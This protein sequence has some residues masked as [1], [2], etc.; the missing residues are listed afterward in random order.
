MFWD[1]D[2]SP[3][4][5]YKNPTW[6]GLVP[7]HGRGLAF[8]T[9]MAL[10]LLQVLAKSMSVA[11][12]AMT[13]STAFAVYMCADYAMFFAWKIIRGD[14]ILFMPMP[15]VPSYIIS[16]IAFVSI[17]TQMDFT[18]CLQYRLPAF[19]GGSFFMFNLVTSQLSVL[20]AAHMYNEHYVDSQ[21]D[22]DGNVVVTKLSSDAIW[23]LAVTL[24]LAWL[25]TMA[26]FIVRVAMPS[27]LR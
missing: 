22:D 25:A 17:K 12:I 10:S 1:I 18:G 20:V 21:L 14:Y 23:Q 9:V 16:L 15:I 4:M 6:M 27:H 2:V 8:G 11:L 3:E 24:S 5:R 7:D 13:S 19:A 26:F